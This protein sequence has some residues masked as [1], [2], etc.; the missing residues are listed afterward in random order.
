MSIFKRNGVYYASISTQSGGR[1]KQSLGTKD[2]TEAKELH[3]KLKH[4]SWRVSRLGERQKRSFDEGALRWLDEMAHKKSIEDD[5][6]FIAHFREHLGHLTLCQ[7]TA[8]HIRDAVN[9]LQK[10]GKPV[11]GARKNRYLSWIRAMLRKAEREW[12]WIDK[13]PTLRLYPEAKRRIRWLTPQEA[14]R[15]IAELPD[16]LKPVITFALHTG[17]RRS[18]VVGLRWDQV[19]MQRQVAWVHGD[20]AKAGKAIGVPLNRS[21]IEAIRSQLGNSTEYVFTFKGK[22]MCV[23]S[24]T[25]WRSALKRAGIGNFRFHDLR[26]T[27]ASWHVQSGTSLVELQEMGG[28]ETAGMVRKYAH[29]ASDH[30]KKSAAK[31]DGLMGGNGSHVPNLPQS[32]KIG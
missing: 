32:K 14:E 26:H 11:T 22:P 9:K 1:I 12:L 20:E 28:W 8:D 17:L 23:T 15:L 10:D 6:T 19:D 21:A 7:I 5:K 13:A 31:L 27:W 24:N 3:D 30:L 29:L 16:H 25:A 18:N 2:E 4:E